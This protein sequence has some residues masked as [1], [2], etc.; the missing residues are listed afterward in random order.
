MRSAITTTPAVDSLKLLEAVKFDRHLCG[1]LIA[2]RDDW[3]EI[4]DSMPVNQRRNVAAVVVAIRSSLGMEADYD[5]CQGR[6]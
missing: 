6:E 4:L 2:T 1:T 3:Q 5:V